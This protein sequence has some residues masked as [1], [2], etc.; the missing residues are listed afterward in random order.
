MEWKPLE[1]LEQS[2]DIIWLMFWEDHPGCI[3][4]AS[5]GGG[6]RRE[7]WEEQHESQWRPGPGRRQGEARAPGP[8]LDWMWEAGHGK[9]GGIRVTPG[10]GTDTWEGGE[11]FT[12]LRPPWEELGWE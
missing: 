2:S 9:K 8:G 4:L 5:W 12:Q 6:G 10:G 3:E 1:G 7:R 11:L